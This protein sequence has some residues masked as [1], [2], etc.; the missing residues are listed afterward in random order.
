MGVVADLAHSFLTTV[1]PSC[2]RY[3]LQDN[4]TCQEKARLSQSGFLN[5]MS[6]LC[7]HQISVCCTLGIIFQHFV[8]SQPEGTKAVVN[9]VRPGTSRVCRKNCT[10]MY[11]GQN[12]HP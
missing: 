6:L 1:Y 8:E 5:M 3:F 4:A 12:A 2:D 7:N 11:L 9:R 10:G